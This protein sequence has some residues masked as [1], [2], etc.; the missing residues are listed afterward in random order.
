MT[1]A[2]RSR[3]RSIT[4]PPAVAADN[5]AD[6][7]G[8]ARPTPERRA[9]G[10][11]VLRDTED[12]GVTVAV[13]EGATQLDRL[14]MRGVITAEQCQAGHDLAAI[15]YRTRLVSAGR[16]CLDWTPVGPDTDDAP[17]TWQQER[18]RVQRTRIFMR[19]RGQWVWP[20]LVRTCRDDEPP[21]KIDALRDGLDVCIAEFKR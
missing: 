4:P 7:D 5:W 6:R 20:E 16:S 14:H 13:D 12:A 8:K 9:K 3:K 19:C 10:A 21:R 1:K 18:D 17:E 11:F 15:L 2:K